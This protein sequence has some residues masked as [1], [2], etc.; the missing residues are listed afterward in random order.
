M[1]PRLGQGPAGLHRA[2][3]ALAQRPLGCQGDESG[4]GLGFVALLERRLDGS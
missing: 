2:R 1:Q 3:D 4:A